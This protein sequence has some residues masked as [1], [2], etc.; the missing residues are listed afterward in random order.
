MTNRIVSVGDDF[1]L[2]AT[3]KVTNAN[4]RGASD[5]LAYLNSVSL[6]CD[7]PVRENGEVSW[8]QGF[9]INKATNEIYVSNQNGTELR[10]DVRDLTTGVR[11][12]SKITTTE[13]GAFTE[14]LS[15]FTNGNGELCFMVWPKA[16]G[17]VPSAYAIFN[18][19]LG[20]LGA[21]IPI[22]GFSRGDVSGNYLVTSD[23]WTNTVTKFYVYD[24]ASV[25][26]GTPS[27]LTTIPVE[28][29]GATAA[30]NQGIAIV[31]GHLYLSQG[32]QTDSPTVMVWDFTG[33]L[34]AVRQYGRTAFQAAVNTLKPGYLSNSAYTYE[35]EGATNLD[36]KLVTGQIVNNNPAVV[37]DSRMLVLQHNRVDGANML[38]QPITTYVYD[39]GWQPLTLEG[40]W[41]VAN[42]TPPMYRRV[43][44][45]V[46]FKGAVTNTTASTT[47]SPFTTLP[48]GFRPT[49]QA[50]YAISSNANTV[51][52]LQITTGGSMQ[53]YSA[54]VTT[55]WR[56]LN[57]VRFLLD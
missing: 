51:M 3:L 27:L 53:L 55:A 28:N 8:P 25:Q 40:T 2:P 57:G 24:W 26:A 21:Q 54:A 47:L 48:V 52:N 41:T 34:R 32:A 4:L 42:G 16:G 49:E 35:A 23:A 37:T 46:R 13:S 10:I 18:Y 36:G 6:L 20:T 7:F 30:K 11:K 17:A 39:T 56:Q 45:E 12:S 31:G 22:Y 50:G 38:A 19:T 5:P 29:T 33:K 44:N 1:S 15:Y 14:S 43:G 9:S